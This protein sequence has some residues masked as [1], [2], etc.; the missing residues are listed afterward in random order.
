[1]PLHAVYEQCVIAQPRAK[2]DG[3][4]FGPAA[5]KRKLNGSVPRQDEDQSTP[6]E[7][8]V[9]IELPP[10]PEGI[11]QDL[12]EEAMDET[13]ATSFHESEAEQP[14]LPDGNPQTADATSAN[15]EPSIE[16][17]ENG[18]ES[19]EQPGDEKVAIPAHQPAAEQTVAPD[20]QMA[21]RF[22]YLLKPHTPS[23]QPQVLIAL[24]SSKPLFDLL[25]DKVILE[26]PTIIV[27]SQ[28]ADNL[29]PEYVSEIAYLRKVKREPLP[30]ILA[31]VYGHVDHEDGET[32]DEAA[33]AA[34]FEEPKI[35]E[36]MKRDSARPKHDGPR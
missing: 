4:R 7:L 33:D 35:L 36:A 32:K 14:P 19:G 5:K 18:D 12:D 16:A 6:D 29:P 28:P 34:A 9:E 11:V 2:R 31:K 24:D 10:E 23:H 3:G 17:K 8:T 20:D 27:L 21:A 22:F 15:T 30:E 1:M 25:Q 13:K 26:F